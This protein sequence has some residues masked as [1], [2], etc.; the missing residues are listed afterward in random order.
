M[1][2]GHNSS[3]IFVRVR[4]RSA[5]RA[6]RRSRVPSF[7]LPSPVCNR[8]VDE[9]R[10]PRFPTG[11]RFLCDGREI[12]NRDRSFGAAAEIMF[13]LKSPAIRHA[14]AECTPRDVNRI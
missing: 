10:V 3:A 7:A 9:S 5:W 12:R 1:R 11:T 8:R 2:A 13:P 4:R 14:R 6:V